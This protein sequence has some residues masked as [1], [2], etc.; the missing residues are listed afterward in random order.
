M[1]YR[2]EKMAKIMQKSQRQQYLITV[3]D[4]AD[5]NLKNELRLCW[6]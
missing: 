1:R 5:K 3:Q 4:K 6:E 2:N